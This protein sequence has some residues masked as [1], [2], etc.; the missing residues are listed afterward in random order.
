MNKT[1]HILGGNYEYY[2]CMC[3]KDKREILYNGS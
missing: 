2:N 3:W 1:V